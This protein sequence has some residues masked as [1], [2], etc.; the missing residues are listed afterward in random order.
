MALFSKKNC[1][2]CGGKIGLLGNRK[3]DDGNM[4]KDCA[5][6]LS[7]FF[8]DRKRSTVADINEHLAYREENKNAVAAFNVTRTLGKGT[9]VHLDEDA[10]KF[11]VTSSNR[12]QQEKTSRSSNS[13]IKKATRLAITRLATSTITILI[14]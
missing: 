3:L 11:I 12:W 9:K 8:S 4:C 14:W 5:K 10:N 7:P 13:G 6:L 2:I 1:D